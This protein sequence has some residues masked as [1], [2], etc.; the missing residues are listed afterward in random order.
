MTDKELQ[1]ILSTRLAEVRGRIALACQRVGRNANEVT[2]VAVTKTVSS[3]VVAIVQELGVND[4]GE[5]RPQE[6]WKK[7]ATAEV[8]QYDY[9]NIVDQYEKLYQT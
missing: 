7:W 4:F 8:K 5:N 3:R 6:L 2:L 1:S 9:K